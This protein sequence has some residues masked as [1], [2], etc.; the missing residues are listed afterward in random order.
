MKALDVALFTFKMWPELSSSVVDP[1][2]FF[3]PGSGF[4][5]DLNFRSGFRSGFGLFMK[6]TFEMQI[7]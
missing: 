3:A 2:F 7:V 6:N 4:Y 1:K 5:F